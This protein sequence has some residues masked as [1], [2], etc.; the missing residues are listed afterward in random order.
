MRAWVEVNLG[1]IERNVARAKKEVG[2][3]VEIM[4]VVKSD[5]YG[6]GLEEIVKATDPLEVDSYA[7]I[8]MEEAYR[9]RQISNKPILIMGYL[10]TKEVTDAISE[11]FILSLYDKELIP[12]YERFA[13]RIG[14][15]ARVHLKV[16]TGLNRLGMDIGDAIDFIANQRHFPNINLEA[17]FSHLYK[18]SDKVA[19]TDQLQQLQQLIAEVSDKAPLVPMHLAS[20]YSLG[21]FKEGYLDG[22]RLGLAIYGIDKVLPDLEPAFTC[23]A[24]VMQVKEVPKGEGISYGHLHTTDKL[25]TVAILPLG[26]AEGLSQTLTGKL[27]ALVQGIERPVLGQICMNH[28]VVDVT[29]LDVK[30]GDEMV[31]IGSQKR[32]DGTM[33]EIRVADVAKKSNIRH[34]EIVTR[35]GRGLPR[36]YTR[37]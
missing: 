30:R 28:I 12:I 26:Y 37:G 8:S 10:D 6:H 20:S 17:V 3:G 19:S 16:E 33:G 13:L 2:S 11:G 32:S 27:S 24:L 14:R 35:L 25:T 5:A 1:A 9:V 23:K 18:S 15:K 22:V 31:I 29:G 4:A 36:I 34:H 7:V 21:Q